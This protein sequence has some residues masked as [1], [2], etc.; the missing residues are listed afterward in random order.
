MQVIIYILRIK[1]TTNPTTTPSTGKELVTI[2]NL[3]TGHIIEQ[4]NC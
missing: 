4:V 3:W 2:F 1:G